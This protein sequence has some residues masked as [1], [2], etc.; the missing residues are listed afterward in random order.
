MLGEE[1]NAHVSDHR[2]G[3]AIQIKTRVFACFPMFF[4]KSEAATQHRTPPH[5]AHHIQCTNSAQHATH[6]KHTP[7]TYTSVLSRVD[8]M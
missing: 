2:L 5:S 8:T 7:H 1:H 3:P 4:S 6:R